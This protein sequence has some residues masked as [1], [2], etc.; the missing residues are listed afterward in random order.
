MNQVVGE[1]VVVIDHQDHRA[2]IGFAAARAK[3]DALSMTLR[4]STLDD[5]EM[6]RAR[7]LLAP[8]VRRDPMWPAL[9]AATLLAVTATLFAS[10]M[11]LA[12]PLVTQHSAR[13]SPG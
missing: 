4:D 7:R 10:A 8:P 5:A 11:V 12:P 2:S 13:T 9:V 3:R 1:A 6:A